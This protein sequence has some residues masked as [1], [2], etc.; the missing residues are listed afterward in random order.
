[1]GKTRN[2]EYLQECRRLAGIY[3][4]Y[5]E[6]KMSEKGLEQTLKNHISKIEALCEEAG[7]CPIEFKRYYLSCIA[8]DTIAK[9]C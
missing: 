2:E 4:E 1:M 9:G 3:V 5:S 7:I 6:L 8:E